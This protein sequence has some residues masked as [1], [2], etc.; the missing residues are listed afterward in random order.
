MR[1]VIA[2]DKFKG[3]LT[4][5]EAAKALARG[6]RAAEPTAEILAVP[7][8]DGGEGVVEALVAATGG[9]YHEARVTGPLGSPVPARFGLLGDGRTAVV[10][11]A[12]AAGLALVP[13]DRRDP[14][15]T[16]TRGVGELMLAAADLGVGRLI[17]GIGGSA[18]NDGGAGMA[19]ALG[20]RLLDAQGRDL[21]PGGGAL[22]ALDR[23]TPPDAGTAL[24]GVE[25]SV[26]CDVT[27]PLCGPTG[28][29][30]VYGPQKGA[31]PDMV[32][33]L[34]R[35]LDRLARIIERD[36]GAAVAEIPGAGPRGASAAVSSR[37]R[38]AAWSV[39]S[40]S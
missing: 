10:E 7:M 8:A 33:E 34:D 5:P 9:S 32:E 26:A 4:A 39:G 25:V 17:V 36:L 40:T 21:A 35:N 6:V 24:K 23:I 20:F 11:M 1:I 12:A 28:A 19:Q 30:A 38:G 18:T 22:R 13:R 14:R 27:N 15:R 29:S 2:P 37:S 16:T 3:S 31:T